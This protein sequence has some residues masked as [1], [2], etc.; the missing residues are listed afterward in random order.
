MQAWRA[1]RPPPRANPGWLLDDA[2]FYDLT[3]QL[4]GIGDVDGLAE[5]F[6]REQFVAA[7]S[8]EAAEVYRMA[9]RR[10]DVEIHVDTG[11]LARPGDVILRATGSAGALHMAWRAAQEVIAYASGVATRTRSLVEVARSVSPRI[12]IATTRKTP[13]G[14][15]ALYFGAVMAGGGVIHRCCLSDGVLLFRN[16]LTFLDGR[17]LSSIIRSLKNANPLRPV[18]IEV[19]TPEEA[20]E[21]AAA[22]ADYVQLERRPPAGRLLHEL[23][24][25]GSIA[26][27]H[28]VVDR[29]A[30]RPPL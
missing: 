4:L 6:A 16:H 21:A 3:T 27:L 15:R 22:G 26:L 5:V 7:G 17:D 23:Q 13:P 18:G 2:G 28:P 30:H 8:E 9:D 25:G 14:L 11:D 10:V 20:I 1:C 19:E 29:C 24:R 12:V